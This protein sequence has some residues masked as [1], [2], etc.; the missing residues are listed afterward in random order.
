MKLVRKYNLKD[1]IPKSTP[2][3]AHV[4]LMKQEDKSELNF[5]YR[6]R[7]LIYL[8]A[9]SIPGIVFD[10]AEPLIIQPAIL[11]IRPTVLCIHTDTDFEGMETRHSTTGFVFVMGGEPVT[12]R[13]QRQ[14]KIG[15][16][17]NYRGRLCS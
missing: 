11:C 8:K 6:K 16:A 15:L 9:T 13:S 3:D 17:I 10:T 1:T 4:R 12:W 2:D 5:P 7:I 14:K